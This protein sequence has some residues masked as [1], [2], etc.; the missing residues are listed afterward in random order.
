MLRA[1]L[2]EREIRQAAGLPAGGGDRVLDGIAIIGAGEDRCL[3]FVS[4][5][6]TAGV[7][8]SLAALRGCVVVAPAGSASA[9]DW[10]DCLVLEAAR[11]RAAVAKV[12]GLIRSERRHA[13]WVTARRIDAGAGVSPLAV[14]EGAVEIGAG[15]VVEPF[16]VIG[17][18]VRIGRGTIIRS[19]ARLF[20]RVE[21]GEES[22]VGANSVIG[23]EGYGFVRD[24]AGSKTRMPHLGGVVIGSRVEIG[25][26]V[27]VPSG[28]IEP[29]VVEDHAKIDDH[30][31][32]GH[33]CR[34]ARG[35]SVTA[36]VLIGGH[37][38]IEEEAWVGMNS[39]IRPGRRVGSRALVGMDV[40][41]QDDLPDE[42]VARAPRP[43]VRPRADADRGAIGFEG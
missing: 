19:G 26:L 40:S 27:T 4:K 42:S 25:A 12:L 5:E 17:P 37:A 24:E 20:P 22:A 7:R 14:V 21:I 30:V 6:V 28:T 35:A 33:N 18:E 38:V 43:D 34:V 1:T 9:G 13:P 39:S 16:C 29:T 32:V 2:H 36:A 11:P 41:L 3:Y 31:H 8:E 23:H 10:G 15:V